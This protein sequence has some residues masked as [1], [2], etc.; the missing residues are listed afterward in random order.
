MPISSSEIELRLDI[1]SML[2]RIDNVSN[3][4]R[5]NG[6]PS[7]ARTRVPRFE[8]NVL[9][10][11]E[12]IGSYP[13]RMSYDDPLLPVPPPPQPTPN[14]FADYADALRGLDAW[15]SDER[16]MRGEKSS[17]EPF[18]SSES[19]RSLMYDHQYSN[20]ICKL[21]GRYAYQVTT[22]RVNFVQVEGDMLTYMPKGRSQE[23]WPDGTWKSEGRQ[24]GKPARIAKM[25]I[26]KHL[27]ENYTD[28]HF[29]QF[30]NIIK[31]TNV[32]SHSKFLRVKG[33][34]IVKYYHERHYDTTTSSSLTQSCMR[35]AKC[36]S[37][38]RMYADNPDIVS[39][40]ILRD[41]ERD[42]IYGR[43]LVWDI[44]GFDTLIMD[45]VYGTD[46]VQQAFR[47][48]A[49]SHGWIYRAYNSF[50]SETSFIHNNELIYLDICV[51]LPNYQFDAYPYL[52][53]MKFFD[54][55]KGTFSNRVPAK[56]RENRYIAALTSTRGDG[57][58]FYWSDLESDTTGTSHVKTMRTARETYADNYA[59]PYEDDGWS[60][61]EDE[62]DPYDY[63]ADETLTLVS[64][65]DELTVLPRTATMTM[66][67]DGV[68]HA[69]I[70][71]TEVIW[72]SYP[73]VLS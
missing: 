52:D 40:V 61:E 18:Y 63:D 53:T 41:K 34:D 49:I 73:S 4:F 22:E 33:P 72:N 57:M 19:F 35:Y 58:W 70:A 31:A 71:P 24:S 46:A 36:S 42:V 14:P 45:R 6:I 44:P 12:M 15:A 48:H 50:E 28:S 8:P 38:L 59:L 69:D 26:P 7:V 23:S 37:Y 43:A 16:Q 2:N 66:T 54:R 27:Q 25:L 62:P 30:A 68:F 10:R 32:S 11:H 20:P 17:V 3:A 55:K 1:Q 21:L 47:K 51:K 5:W 65:D 56:E 64:N 60:D 9:G 67:S 39:L 29:E 13:Q